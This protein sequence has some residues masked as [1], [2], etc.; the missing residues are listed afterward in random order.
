M[1][2]DKITAVYTDAEF[3]ALTPEFQQLLRRNGWSAQAPVGNREAR[4]LV[5]SCDVVGVP[6]IAEL[7]RAVRQRVKALTQ[8]QWTEADWQDLLR[9]QRL[10]EHNLAAR[11]GL[12]EHHNSVSTNPSR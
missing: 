7:P 3:R 5:G 10:I 12:L 4:Q 1:S 9:T 6:E 11:H 2:G 8:D